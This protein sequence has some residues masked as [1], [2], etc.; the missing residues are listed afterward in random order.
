VVAGETGSGKSTQLPKL[1]LELGRGQDQWIGHTQPRRLAARTIA[2]RVADEL[3]TT[4]GG[5]VGYA[6]RFTDKVGA[7]TRLKLMTD[8]ILLAELS[9]D[10]K[11]S[12]YDTIIIDEAHERSLNIDFI[13][14]YLAQLLPRRRD[15]K[16]IVTSATIDTERF[17]EH[18]NNAPIIEVSGRTYPVDVRYEPMEDGDQADAIADAAQKLWRET[19]G[20]ILV[21]CSG[22][23]EIRD[24][25]ETLAE[26]RLPGAE[27]L[28]L[29]ARLSANEQHRVFAAH[30]Q[31]RIVVATNVAET[32]LTVPG[33]R[34]IIDTG[35][36][37]ISRYSARTK[38]QRLPIEAISQASA[39]QRSGRA[40][41]VAPGICIRLYGEDDFLSRP[42]F[43]EP[44]IQRTNLASVILQMASLGLGNIDQFPFVDRPDSRAIKDG[45]NLLHELHALNPD[46]EG[47]R[48][49]LTPTGRKLAKLPIDPR[50]GRMLLEAANNN[51]V[52]EVMIIVSGL[53]IQDPRERPAD[54]REAAADSHRR[55]AHDS[56]SDFLAYLN[57]WEY[58][59]NERKAR[60]RNQFRRM[61][62]REFLHYHRVVEWT[63]IHR[64]LRQVARELDIRSTRGGGPDA[65]HRSILAGL[66]S[67][68]GVKDTKSEQENKAQTKGQRNP[69]QRRRLTEYIGARNSRFAIA[70]GSSAGTPEWTMA[71]ELVE[72]NRLWARTVAEIDPEW[73]EH[74]AQHLAR[75]SYSEPTWDPKRGA[76]FTKERVTL[77]GLTLAADR[78]RPLA[79]V[80]PEA[81]R[82]MF[83]HHALVLGEI[84]AKWSHSF[85]AHNA[86]LVEELE[87]LEARSRRRDLLADTE[88]RFGFYDQRL[89]ERITNR[90]RF[91]SWWIKHRNQHPDLLNMTSAVLLTEEADTVDTDSFPDSWVVDGHDL[92]VVYEFDPDSH[93]DGASVLVPVEILNQLR[94]EPFTWGVPGYRAELITAMVR[95]LPKAIRKQFVPVNETTAN[96]MA[97]T[98]DVATNPELSQRDI[99]HAVADVLGRSVGEVIAPDT[100]DW[101]KVQGHLQPTFRVV[102]RD[103]ALLAEGKSLVALQQQL[104]AQM[105]A[106]LA[107]AVAADQGLERQGVVSWD[108][109]TL[110][111]VVET[112]APQGAPTAG[113]IKAY[114][115]VVDEGDSVAIRLLA[116][117]AEQHDAMWDGVRRLLRIA[118]PRPVRTLDALVPQT[119]KLKLVNA[120]VQSKAEW[121]NDAIDVALDAII[122]RH[123]GPP[124]HEAGFEALVQQGRAEFAD[125]LAEAAEG[126]VNLVDALA[127]IH[128]RLDTRIGSSTTYAVSVDDIRA[129]L[130]RL[131][132][133]G[134]MVGVGLERLDDVHRYLLGI[135]RRLDNLVKHPQLDLQ[136]TA[137]VRKL[138][139]EFAEVVHRLHTGGGTTIVTDSPATSPSLALGYDPNAVE[140]LTWLLEELRVALFAQQ[141]GT[142]G[143]ASEKRVRSAL[144]R[145]RP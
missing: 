100:F 13:L 129:H 79:N 97:A 88:R 137:T 2:E 52:E 139:N 119:T 80:D 128:H 21:F 84:E 60:S 42:E 56:G 90:D 136:N 22:E 103:Y 53:S 141:L 122:A 82:D 135:S 63:D 114:P 94:P 12:R 10:R 18:F 85:L 37:R 27:L 140:D 49:W 83:I 125:H 7:N 28:P 55:F 109:G 57:L 44:E 106:T 16:V 133:P 26:L 20:D 102:D 19:D 67:H 107:E 6:V 113:G 72:T 33:V 120:H 127:E 130:Q 40:G 43:T 62:R 74:L 96:V 77:F 144:N 59:N 91:D 134:F 118:L 35:T 92:E 11:L 46:R 123:G 41:R 143:R 5:A 4:I 145:L 116:N 68:I 124:W 66:L 45:I 126:L 132:Y 110:P 131:A 14:G 86:K 108:F 93:L 75:Y 121:Y 36:A 111:T 117:E 115:A 87:L 23:R 69:R 104:D 29:Y 47:T 51:C 15:L 34:S 112:S 95:A 70:P 32:S 99:R 73:A 9:R 89:P 1:C 38:V 25:I 48:K 58:L 54:Q 31:R 98:A 8:G 138:D 78:T 142:K 101:S 71:G 17:S 65:I 76:A 39:N 61:C 64:Q 81:A 105:R 3:D 24:A 50:Y 30:R